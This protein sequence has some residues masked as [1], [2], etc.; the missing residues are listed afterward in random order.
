VTV[1]DG[2][3]EQPVVGASADELAVLLCLELV[4]LRQ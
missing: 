2:E 3:M 4:D 1:L